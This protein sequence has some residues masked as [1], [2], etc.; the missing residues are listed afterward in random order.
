MKYIILVLGFV[1][2]FVSSMSIY[3][4]LEDY[5]KSAKE[6]DSI[7]LEGGCASPKG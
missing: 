2:M 5:T 6:E 3:W 4:S 1:V 7:A